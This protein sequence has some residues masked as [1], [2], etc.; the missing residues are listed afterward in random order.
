MANKIITF[1]NGSAWLGFICRLSQVNNAEHLCCS[2][3]Y[4]LST[5]SASA[6]YLANPNLILM[7]NR[8]EDVSW[9]F[10]ETNYGQHNYVSESFIIIITL[11]LITPRYQ[12]LFPESFPW[13][14]KLCS[15]MGHAIVL[16]QYF[17][18][19]QIKYSC[20]MFCTR[21]SNFWYKPVVF[22]WHNVLLFI[23]L[24]ERSRLD[25]SQLTERTRL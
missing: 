12:E 2:S 16:M 17:S 19:R 14:I 7:S 20:F 15:A 23:P 6:R 22:D 1:S 8:R 9:F 5:P 21:T 3:V 13:V 4:P 18:I 11:W 10:T 25:W 24:L